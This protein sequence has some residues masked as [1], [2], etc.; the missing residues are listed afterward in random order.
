MTLQKQG[1]GLQLLSAELF[2]DQGYDAPMV[3]GPD[4]GSGSLTS[5][6]FED[7]VLTAE[8]QGQF[9]RLTGYLAGE[10]KPADG[11]S[12]QDSVVRWQVTLPPLE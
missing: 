10:P 5:H 9:L 3:M 7:D 1:G 2:D 6:T 12:P 8:I 4:G 11:A